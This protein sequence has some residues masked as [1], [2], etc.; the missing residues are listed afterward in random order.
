MKSSSCR[1][2]ATFYF[3]AGL[4]KTVSLAS[5]PTTKKG[6][7]IEGKREAKMGFVKGPAAPLRSPRLPV[8]SSAGPVATLLRG[9][10]LHSGP[11]I[12][13]FCA[14]GEGRG[15]GAGGGE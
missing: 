9:R 14:G 1:N 6:Q 4:T 2:W 10:A 11:I 3:S 12:P 15:K 7:E 8:R 5:L 13:G